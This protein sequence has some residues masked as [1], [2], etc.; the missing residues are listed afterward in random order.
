V[1][2]AGAKTKCRTLSGQHEKLERARACLRTKTKESQRRG[3]L[4]NHAEELL[5]A[6]VEFVNDWKKGDFQ[7][8]ELASCDA[9]VMKDKA[10]IFSKELAKQPL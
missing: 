2:R 5:V 1:E 3:D 8:C 9:E 10:V 6:V 7:L 4:L